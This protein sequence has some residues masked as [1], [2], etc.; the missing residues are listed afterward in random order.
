MA[1][2]ILTMI[3]KG[4]PVDFTKCRSFFPSRSRAG[5]AD[6]LVATEIARINDAYECRREY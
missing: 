5:N 3:R 4:A 1:A 2:L 6:S